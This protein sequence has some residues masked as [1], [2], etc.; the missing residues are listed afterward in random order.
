MR[1]KIFGSRGSIAVS[2]PESIRY[3]GNTAAIEVKGRDGTILILDAGTGIRPLGE[4]LR[5]R[6]G[7]KLLCHGS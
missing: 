5:P 6:N 4:T 1:V 3:G 2:G 7:S